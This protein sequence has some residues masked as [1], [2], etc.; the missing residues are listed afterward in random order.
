MAHLDAVTGLRR[1]GAEM[2]RVGWDVVWIP[3]W[4]TRGMGTG[5]IR[6]NG[7]VNHWTAG[8]RTGATPSLNVVTFGR[9]GLRNALCNTYSSRH[10]KPKLY[11]VAARVAWHA[12]SGSYG[13]LRGNRELGHEA[14]CAG[15]GLW[16]P[17]QLD[18]QADLSYFQ[19]DVFGYGLGHVIDHYEWTSR[20]TDRRDVGGPRW[21]TRLADHVPGA[22]TPSGE[23][24]EMSQAI[25]GIQT[26]LR[27]AGFTDQDGQPLT[28]DGVWGWKTQYAFRRAM[29]AAKTAPTTVTNITTPPQLK[30]STAEFLE[31]F[32]AA[33]ETV[34]LAGGDGEPQAGT[35]TSL[36]HVLNGFRWSRRFHRT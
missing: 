36:W 23:D 4:E 31:R 3:G 18:L 33:A 22:G 8:A 6:P 13:S 24:D 20:K 29:E 2:R 9:S 7:E 5:P 11:V 26:E 32:V 16:A 1:V 35:P 27:R 12:G 30:P 17:G 14:E 19:M 15:P 21:R 34:P 10:S 25:E 28:S